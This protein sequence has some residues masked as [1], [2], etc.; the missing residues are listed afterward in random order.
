MLAFGAGWAIKG[1]VTVAG[2][3]HDE[4]MAGARMSLSPGLE[5]APGT[6]K[7][8]APLTYNN[9]S[10]IWLTTTY[11][12]TTIPPCSLLRYMLMTRAHMRKKGNI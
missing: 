3:G 10:A 11:K 5:A 12:I 4:G 2:I 7:V 9:F 6:R 1:R 8:L